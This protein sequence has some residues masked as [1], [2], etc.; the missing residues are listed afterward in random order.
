MTTWTPHRAQRRRLLSS[1]TLITPSVTAADRA[2]HPRYPID[3]PAMSLKVPA[4]AGIHYGRP[5]PSERTRV[6]DSIVDPLNLTWHQ[7]VQDILV[8]DGD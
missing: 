2:P 1:D 8:H 5:C 7:H 6:G 4:M 3:F